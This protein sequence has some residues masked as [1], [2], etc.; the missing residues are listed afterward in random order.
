VGT[1]IWDRSK[2][3]PVPFFETVICRASSSLKKRRLGQT[4]ASLHKR[5]G[6]LPSP[7]AARQKE[8]AVRLALDAGCRQ[9]R[10]CF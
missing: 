3:M 9:I 4:E 8:M 6:L 2:S 5:R 10:A 1:G 7:A